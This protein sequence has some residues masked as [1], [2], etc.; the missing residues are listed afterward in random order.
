MKVLALTPDPSALMRLLAEDVDAGL[1]LSI[2]S[3]LEDGLDRIS[4]SAW[5]LVLVDST[6]DDE[7][8][9]VLERIAATGQRAVLLARSASV[10]LTLDAL[11]RGAWDMLPF[12]IDARE[13]RDI[14]ARSR[15]A[16]EAMGVIG[17][18]S[19]AVT[20][21]TRARRTSPPGG[22]P[23]GDQFGPADRVAG[24]VSLVGESPAV[25]AVFQ[26]A[27]RVADSTTPVLV[28]G[29]KGTGKTLLARFLHERSRRRDGPFVS[30]HCAGVPEHV[31]ESD[32]FGY[33]KGA[34]AG[35]AASR[36]GRVE[37]A[38]GGT[39]L[40]DEV[41]ELPQPLQ[42]KM[43]R[44]LQESAVERLGGEKTVP[45]DIRLLA[46]ASR[47][48]EA[49]VAA[50]RFLEDLHSRLAV[51]VITLPTLR[52]RGDDIRLLAEYCLARGARDRGW[53][54][55]AIAPETFEVLR[56]YSW[57]G[58]VRQLCNVM[59]RALFAADGPVLLPT[60]LPPEIRDH[61][62][63]PPAQ[64]FERRSGQ[65]RRTTQDRRSG[66]TRLPPL[67]ALERDHIQRAL[68][69][70]G[71]HLGRTAELLGI[72]R[73]TLRRKL[74]DLELRTHPESP[75]REGHQARD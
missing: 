73:N 40:L 38:H 29:E 74:R 35:A 54:V 27:A 11:R 13:L 63:A 8:V 44:V 72:H 68:A 32:I 48:L 36:A 20:V 66:G 62:A 2:E 61:P 58:N 4:E 1:E 7:I 41:G 64:V 24:A 19:G 5:S 14:L 53:Q 71:H 50:G 55:E 57:P 75:G 59:E 46:T 47:P 31:L 37:R 3:S 23:W 15:A 28:Q 70:T 42:A 60:H 39:F 17:R 22:I 51:V 49:E 6:L 67:E 56:R 9:D 16:D 65:E 34:F 43:L 21:D 33:E 10:E 45:V 69:L 26:A 30:V 18:R 12:P 25:V 52:E